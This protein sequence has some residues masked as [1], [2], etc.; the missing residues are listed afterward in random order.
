MEKVMSRRA[1]D[2]H[3]DGDARVPLASAE[4]KEVGDTPYVNCLHGDLPLVTAV[5]N[6]VFLW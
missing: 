2:P 5:Y 1:G 3:R 4:L 6:N